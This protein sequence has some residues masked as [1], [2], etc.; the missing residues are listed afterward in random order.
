MVVVLT[1][2]LPAG[3]NWDRPDVCVCPRPTLLFVRVQIARL[4]KKLP[5]TVKAKEEDDDDLT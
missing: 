1:T 4:A 2:T 3:S 5:D